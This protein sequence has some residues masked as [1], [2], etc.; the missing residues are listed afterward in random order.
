MLRIVSLICIAGLA[1]C[2]SSSG[3]G[4]AMQYKWDYKLVRMPDDTYRVYEHPKEDVVM[5]TT[6][7]STAIGT[8]VASGAI[9]GLAQPDTPEHRHEAAARK[10]LNDTGR[11][12]CTITRGYLL[13][14]LQYE[15]TY[16]C[17]GTAG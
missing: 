7:V 12:R 9:F 17:P 8:G 6:S 15:F 16:S 3:Y 13:I 4:R 5:T 11:A 10:Y 2:A 14:R 1:G